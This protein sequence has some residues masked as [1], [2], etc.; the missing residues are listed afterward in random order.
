LSAT[1]GINKRE[2][3]LLHRRLGHVPFESLSKLY[4]EYFK[5]MDKGTIMCDACEMAKHTRS[6]YPSI[7]LRSSE[8][9]IL[10]HSDVWGPCSITSVS[11]FKWFVTFIDCY[12]R[13]TWI[14]MLKHK[15]E[16]VRCF[17]DFHKLVTNQFNARVQI[18]R[19]DNGTEYV[20][21]EFISYISDQGIIHQTTCPG[22][23]SQNGVAE[24][25]NRHLLE[26]A[27]SLMFQMNVP[28]YLWSEAVMT[29]AYLINRMPSRILGMRS[30][31]ELLLGQR[32]F[33]VPPR[34]FGCVCFVHDHRPSKGKLDPQAV[35]C[36][37]VGYA[38]TQKGYKCW[39]PMGRRLFVSMDVTFREF[40]PYYTN[41][42]DF[43]QFFEEFP[44]TNESD[45]RQD[46]SNSKEGENGTQEG[47]IIGRIPSLM[48]KAVS[49]TDDAKEGN[50]VHDDNEVVVVGTIP[51]PRDYTGGN[52]DK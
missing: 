11:G 13:M 4:P 40:E 52:Q 29:A 22:T 15:N 32:E 12:T 38:S 25:K 18:I 27:R 37:F 6:T 19:T 17:K 28:K 45:C 46:E 9:F 49:G 43:D 3:V 5:G 20:N 34:V 16:V 2:I 33:K 41:Q 50:E 47:T 35:K 23:P 14:Y 21:N 24:R 8:P 48:D 1:T 44:S 31:V 39:D 36:V 7:G 51:C 26:V 42:C 30:P 10:I